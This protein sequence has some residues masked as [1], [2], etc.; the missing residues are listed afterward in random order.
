[1]FISFY[2]F[3]SLLPLF[4]VFEEIDA[5]LVFLTC[6]L[7]SHQLQILIEFKKHGFPQHFYNHSTHES[8][9]SD[10]VVDESSVLLLDFQHVLLYHSLVVVVLLFLTKIHFRGLYTLKQ[11]VGI[12]EERPHTRGA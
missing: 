6:D 4:K 5:L 2:F 10:D 9:L 7:G 12:V 11:S 3:V 1:M 8:R